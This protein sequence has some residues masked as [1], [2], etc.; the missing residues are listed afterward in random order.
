MHLLQGHLPWMG[1]PVNKKRERHA[2][3]SEVKAAT[4]FAEPC[5]G[6]PGEFCK[7]CQLVRGLSF[8][9]EPGYERCRRMSRVRFH[10][11]FDSNKMNEN[12]SQSPKQKGRS[13]VDDGRLDLTTVLDRSTKDGGEKV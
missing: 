8:A 3:T 10:R 11:E 9:E 2:K 1:L 7:Q 5:Q 13:V 6:L 12:D 4:P